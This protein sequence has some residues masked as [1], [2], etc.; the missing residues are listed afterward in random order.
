MER[1]DKKQKKMKEEEEEKEQKKTSP[2]STHYYYGSSF[3]VD[4]SPSPIL[5]PSSVGDYVFLGAFPPSFMADG[6]DLA[7]HHVTG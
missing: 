2:D 1:R 4:L 5:P 3:I 7:I 6:S